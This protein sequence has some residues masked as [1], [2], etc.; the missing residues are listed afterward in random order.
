M[1]KIAKIIL[2]LAINKKFDYKVPEG[3][4]IKSGMRV[5]V[6]FNKKKKI[7][8]VGSLSTKSKIDALKPIE[9]V[10]DSNPILGS[11]HF[12]LAEKLASYYPYPASDFLF[13]M[14]PPELRKKKKHKINI[15]LE[16]NKNIH[17]PE[18]SEFIKFD[19]FGNR[20]SIWK[21]EVKT[22]L[23][24]GSVVICLPQLTF[25]KK[26]STLLKKDFPEKT[27]EFFSQQSDKELLDNWINSRKKSL[28][29]GTRSALFYFPE[30]T[31]IIII[32]EETSPYYFQ[33]VK[34]FYHLRKVAFL[35][36]QQLQSKIILS[37]SYPSLEIYDKIN[38]G[39]IKLVEPGI[40]KKEI[41]S[42]IK[43]VS[44]NTFTKNKYIN[45]ILIEL[46]RKTITEDKKGVL[47][48]NKKNFWRIMAC[49]N[50]DNILCCEY[51]SAFLHQEEKNKE[52]L[53]C[54]YCKKEFSY[55]KICPKCK[56]GYFKGKGMGV[57]KL[58]EIIQ[59][60]FP[61]IKLENFENYTSKSRLIVSTSKILNLLYSRQLFDKGFVLDADSYLSSFDFSITFKTFIYLKNLALLFKDNLFV[62]SSRPDYYLFKYLIKSW[63][64]FYEKEL[65][66][67]KQLQLP[68]FIKIIKVILRHN[69]NEKA[70]KNSKKLYN[71]FKEKKY[72]V[73]GPFE[74]T[75]HKLRG[76]YRYSL[77]VKVENKSKVDKLFHSELSKIKRKG[78]QAAVIIQ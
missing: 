18:K 53:L 25:L 60:F 41:N 67:R 10:I 76:K 11:N 72:N 36:N 23:K 9:E 77:I 27:F 42:K 70:L 29:L 69:E 17:N 38:R 74:E 62:F 7:G 64:K 45:P 28:I 21:K 1:S 61:E 54:P 71:I 75:P 24:K 57:N 63:H 51:C 58:E 66:L 59:K 43:V 19:F 16:K 2:P 50:C 73:Y 20:Y 40:N 8:I 31:K 56:K 68:P 14:L 13:M 30:D 49:T 55:P 65:L 78:V 34:P 22:A 47:I 3:K 4:N 15:I 6:D 35:L 44:R 39:K 32:E 26:I 33:E 52:K 48:W 12:A 37:G 5:L 46:I